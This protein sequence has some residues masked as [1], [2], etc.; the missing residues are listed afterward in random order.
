MQSPNSTESGRGSRAER[1][2][3]KKAGSHGMLLTTGAF[4]IVVCV[5]LYGVFASHKDSGNKALEGAK[6]PADTQSADNGNSGAK[7]EDASS[8]AASNDSGGGKDPGTPVS[9]NDGAGTDSSSGGST[10][11]GANGGDTPVA[12]GDAAAPDANAGGGSTGSAG[13]AGSS[14]SGSGT[15]GST[16][17]EPV[18]TPDKPDTDK[19]STT[20]PK[21]TGEDT[22]G[23]DASTSGKPASKP[24]TTYVVRKGDTLSTISLKF[25]GS[26]QYVSFLAERNGIAFVNDMK[27]GDK[28][29][30]PALTAGAGSSSISKDEQA[31]YAKVK[32]P[33]VYLVRPGDTLYRISVLFYKSGEYVSLIAKKNKLDENAGLKA[34]V[35]LTIPAKPAS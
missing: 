7:G 11:S 30:I 35:S 6:P 10:G 15:E 21:E 3:E 20:P 25:Y 19:G 27:P 17:F 9:S 24:A 5:I 4:L 8:G 18:K 14:G 22:G 32:L 29:R 13:H 23:K 33:A 26:K 12:S 31:D 28:I 16:V 34:G 2:R 1:A